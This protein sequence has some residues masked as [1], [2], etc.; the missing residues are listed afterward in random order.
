MLINNIIYNDYQIKITVILLLTIEGAQKQNI[1]IKTA[2]RS[3]SNI[4]QLI[5]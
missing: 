3:I 4:I 5:K 2:N 1:N